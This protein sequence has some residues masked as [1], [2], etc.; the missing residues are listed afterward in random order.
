[1]LEHGQERLNFRV[2]DAGKAGAALERVVA[3]PGLKRQ[4]LLVIKL[5]DADARCEQDDT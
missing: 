3:Q 5:W 4:Q 1:M 2:G